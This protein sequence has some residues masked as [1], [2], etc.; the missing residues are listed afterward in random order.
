MMMFVISSRRQNAPL[1]VRCFDVDADLTPHQLLEVMYNSIDVI[2]ERS[3]ANR[4]ELGNFVG[5]IAVV[6]ATRV[7]GQV[8]RTGR[9]TMIA[10]RGGEVGDGRVRGVLRKIE[11]A[12]VKDMGNCLKNVDEIGGE[13]LEKE[14]REAVMW[15]G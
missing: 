4:G 3:S 13:R 8:T 9:K 15:Y 12:V 11:T 1:F 7:Y 14:V 10:V 5:C 6:G 2:E